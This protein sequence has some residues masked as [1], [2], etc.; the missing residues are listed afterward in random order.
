MVF[1]IFP[2][3]TT[4]VVIADFSRRRQ[5]RSAAQAPL[6]SAVN[7][8]SEISIVLFL[9]RERTDASIGLSIPCF[10][11]FYFKENARVK[12]SASK[13]Y[14]NLGVKRRPVPDRLFEIEQPGQSARMKNIIRIIQNLEKKEIKLWIIE[15]MGGHPAMVSSIDSSLNNKYLVV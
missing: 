6:Q 5:K 14:S 15:P 3:S 4:A 13:G 9:L 1:S 2:N 11:H 7:H 10:V 8:Q 12:H